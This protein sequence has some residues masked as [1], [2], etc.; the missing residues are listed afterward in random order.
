MTT[1]LN[2]STLR[3]K[4]KAWQFLQVVSEKAHSLLLNALV[5]R[6]QGKSKEFGLLGVS[7]ALKTATK[8]FIPRAL[9]QMLLESA[10]PGTASIPFAG[11]AMALARA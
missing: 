10:L 5:D 7:T 8:S 1:E 3:E 11:I 4:K 2:F 9:L 6:S